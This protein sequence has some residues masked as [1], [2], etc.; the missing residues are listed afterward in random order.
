L[1]LVVSR[2]HEKLTNLNLAFR[3]ERNLLPPVFYLWCHPSEST[4]KHSWTRGAAEIDK[5]KSTTRQ[6]GLARQHH[7]ANLKEKF[8]MRALCWHGK[9]DIRCDRVPDPAIEHPRD[10]IVKVTSTAICGSDLHLYDDFVPGMKSG[11]I[12][13][14]E[15][16]GEVVEVGS[17]N[18]KLKIGDRV[19]V[20]FTIICGECDQCRRGYFSVC[21]RTTATRISP[22][23]SLGTP[24]PGSSATR[25]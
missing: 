20:P 5:Q 3:P 21:E 19:V 13:G 9:E 23:R 14:H 17:E 15:F 4:I 25:I 7:L 24:L 8:L 10:A 18:K 12:M 11:D 6:A 1:W 22:T 16:M 2:V